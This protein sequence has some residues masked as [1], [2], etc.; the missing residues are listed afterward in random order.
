MFS[1]SQRVTQPLEGEFNSFEIPFHQIAREQGNPR[2]ANI[3]ALGLLV[4][5]GRFAT[6]ENL[7][8][9]I[10]KLTPQRFRSVNSTVAQAG[11]Q[12]ARD[13]DLKS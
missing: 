11:K 12:W 8:T 9:A 6:Q 4:E 13:L 3:V 7:Q 5:L 2:G 10:E 1:D